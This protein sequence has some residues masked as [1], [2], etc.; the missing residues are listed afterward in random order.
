[1]RSF[2]K[3]TGKAMSGT[4]VLGG[5]AVVFFLTLASGI[6]V[7]LPQPVVSLIV[8]PYG[9]HGE[10]D[11]FKSGKVTVAIGSFKTGQLKWPGTRLF[12]SDAS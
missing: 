5:P 9:S 4:L 10:A 3:L 12:Y 11:L 1:M 8:R 6:R 2:A 7:G